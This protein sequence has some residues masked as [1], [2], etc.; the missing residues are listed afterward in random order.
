MPP[1]R[2]K[3]CSRDIER[4]AEHGHEYPSH[5]AQACS[6]LHRRKHVPGF[7]TSIRKRQRKFISI[8][9]FALACLC[10][11]GCLL[12]HLLLLLLLLSAFPLCLF[13]WSLAFMSFPFLLFLLFAIGFGLIHLHCLG[14]A[15]GSSRRRRGCI[16]FGCLSYGGL[17]G[18]TVKWCIVVLVFRIPFCRRHFICSAIFLRTLASAAFHICREKHTSSIPS[19][20]SFFFSDATGPIPHL[21]GYRSLSMI[22]LLTLATTP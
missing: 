1:S 17:R 13:L 15:V 9:V 4:V 14:S 18:R 19:D 21:R 16:L 10:P 7:E 5:H 12:S 11:L 8:A 20:F 22:H 6:E 2:H 3:P